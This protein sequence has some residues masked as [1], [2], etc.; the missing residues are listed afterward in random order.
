MTRAQGRSHEVD[1]ARTGEAARGC[2][3]L[4]EYR[5]AL[6]IIC[7]ARVVAFILAAGLFSS[8]LTMRRL[9]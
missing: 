5:H 1:D 4:S 3:Y 2:H 7:A 9:L 6:A 8:P